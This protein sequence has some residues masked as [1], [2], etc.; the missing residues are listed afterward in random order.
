MGQQDAPSGADLREALL[1]QGQGNPVPK[2]LPNEL[3]SQAG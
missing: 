1:L 2:T 3:P